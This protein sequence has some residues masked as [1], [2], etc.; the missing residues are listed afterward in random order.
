MS[1]N[2]D[3]LLSN[4]TNLIYFFNLGYENAL[5]VMETFKLTNRFFALS[6][7]TVDVHQF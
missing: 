2:H 4:P 7:A 1:L 3:C 6:T 5:N